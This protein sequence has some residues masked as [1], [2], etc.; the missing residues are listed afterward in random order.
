ML[1]LLVGF[2]MAAVL[3]ELL[4]HAFPVSTG[5]NFGAVDSRRPIVH[6]GPHF[7]YTYSKDWNFHLANSGILNN[8][9]FR[10]PV[11][12]HA[13][14]RSL[15]VIGNS[16]VQADGIEPSETMPSRLGVMLQRPAYA[17]GADGATLADYLAAARWAEYTF[18]SRTLLVLLTTGDLNHACGPR[19]GGYYLAPSGGTVALALVDRPVQSPFKA[20]INR[21][22]LFRYVYDNLR[23]AANWS[24]GW[25]RANDRD[26][27]PVDPDKLAGLLGCTDRKFALAATTFLLRS[28]HEVENR[29]GARVIFVLAPGYR[30]EQLIDAGGVRDVDLLARDAEADGFRVIPLRESFSDALQAGVRLDFLPIDAHWNTTAHAIAARTVA[31]ALAADG[32][33]PGADQVH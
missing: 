11:D 7:R 17:I 6:G 2:F 29:R 13:D 4:L 12:Y 16:Y 9:G 18:D 32:T 23:A 28:F 10:S 33:A 5:Y 19:L 27:T 20:L 22:M 25:Q 21:S 24:N 26:D 30:R 3:C 31:S 8:Y 14:A 1:P 15:A